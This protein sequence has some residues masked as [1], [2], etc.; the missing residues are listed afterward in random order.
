[1]CFAR[2][3]SVIASNARS[4]M[5]LSSTTYVQDL[6]P[7]ASDTYKYCFREGSLKEI[8]DSQDPSSSEYP[9]QTACH[10]IHAWDLSRTSA[11]LQ[12]LFHQLSQCFDRFTQRSASAGQLETQATAQR[13]S[14]KSKTQLFQDNQKNRNARK[15]TRYSVLLGHSTTIWVSK[16]RVLQSAQVP[17][18]QQPAPRIDPKSNISVRIQQK[19]VKQKKACIT[20]LHMLALNAARLLACCA[21]LLS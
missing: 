3:R 21:H 5:K 15:G 14:L 6:A 13:S 7:P 4:H 9:R 2:A 1:M 17:A 10:G 19:L 8:C 11:Y 16:T 18:H 12:Q 20:V